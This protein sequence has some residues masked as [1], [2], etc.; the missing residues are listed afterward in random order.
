MSLTAETNALFL[1]ALNQ[2]ET[3]LALALAPFADLKEVLYKVKDIQD[4][5]WEANADLLK[6]SVYRR[7][8][9][10]KLAEKGRM[11]DPAY[12]KA[13]SGAIAA[14]DDKASLES[15]FEH[16]M[17]SG[18]HD[19]ALQIVEKVPDRV[20]M[21]TE[22][23]KE[24]DFW[25]NSKAGHSC[26]YAVGSG[27]SICLDT[28]RVMDKLGVSLPSYLSGKEY[29]SGLYNDE[30]AAER[31]SIQAELVGTTMDQEGIE[32]PRITIRG[33]Q[34]KMEQSALAKAFFES[35]DHAQR[36]GGWHA[37]MFPTLIPVV[38]DAKDAGAVERMGG[39]LISP[40]FEYRVVDSGGQ[41]QTHP[42]HGF[43]EPTGVLTANEIMLAT[44][45]LSYEATSRVRDEQFQSESRIALLPVELIPA[46]QMDDASPSAALSFAMR[47]HRPEPLLLIQEDRDYCS[48]FLETRI[49]LKGS[50][51]IFQKPNGHFKSLSIAKELTGDHALSSY[52]TSEKEL[53]WLSTYIRGPHHPPEKYTILKHDDSLSYEA[54]LDSLLKNLERLNKSLGAGVAYRVSAPVAFYEFMEKKKLGLTLPIEFTVPGKPP[55]GW[56]LHERVRLRTSLGYEFSSLVESIGAK[57]EEWLTKAVRSKDEGVRQRC[58]GLL[59]RIPLEDVA[60]LATS[61][62]RAQ[63]ILE[64]FDMAP[65][66]DL[67]PARLRDRVITKK[68]AVDLGL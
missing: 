40:S 55:E 24:F 25:R 15:L 28:F 5:D 8:E 3:V 59:D 50:A 43:V 21:S 68:F 67:L 41:V 58:M 9:T 14:C 26:L 65:I 1:K 20:H 56:N 66:S 42:H 32:I 35:R 64:N 45:L 62:P 30:W 52:F 33:G 4:F 49:Y 18:V 23:G 36:L 44:S 34:P 27:Q 51:P 17:R 53:A 57:P 22:L 19:L 37:D 48:S 2:G 31:F 10:D 6:R 46:L 11:I 63:F 7:D 12:K 47:H 29:S 61:E 60:K 54:N 39:F 13:L 38:L 16:L